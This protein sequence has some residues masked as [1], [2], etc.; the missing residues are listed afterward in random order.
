[1]GR[2][3]ESKQLVVDTCQKLVGKGFLIGTGGNVSVRVPGE[4]ALAITP[5]NYDYMKMSPEDICILTLDLKVIEGSMKPSIESSMHAAIYETRADANVVVHTHQ[6]YAST[7]ALINEPIP[8]LYDE[9]VRFLGRSVEIVDYA[10]SGTPFLKKAIV[11]KLRNQCN[12]YIMKNHGALCL[13]SSAER[14][15]FN[16]ELLEKCAI[17]YLLALCTDKKVSHIPLPIREIAVAKLRS[18]Q[19]KE[20]KQNES[21]MDV[22]LAARPEGEPQHD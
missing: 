11:S 5:S 8:A 9:Q 12:A 22:D 7:F 13:A 18:D 6:I 3:D 1:M 10:P 4:K 16:V 15:I 20:A 2:Y 19:K 21:L 17:T 14:A